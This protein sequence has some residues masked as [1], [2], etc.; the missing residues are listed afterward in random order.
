MKSRALIAIWLAI[1]VTPLMAAPKLEPDLALGRAKVESVCMTCHTID[2]NSAA[3]IY[4]ILAGQHEEYIQKQLQDFKSGKRMDNIMRPWALTLT[5]QDIINVSAYYAAQQL[6]QR[7]AGDQALSDAGGQIYRGGILAK[8]VPACMACHGPNGAGIPS[9]YPQLHSQHAAYTEAQL[10]LFKKNARQNDAANM[11]RDIAMKL[12][13]SE[14]KA[15]AEYISGL[16]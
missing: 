14:I 10:Q 3:P 6:K 9:Q 2:G 5:E 1:V 13:D 11:M 4:P 16:R 15:L 8:N 12:S 7:T